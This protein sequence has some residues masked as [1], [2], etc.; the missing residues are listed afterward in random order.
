MPIKYAFLNLCF[1]HLSLDNSHRQFLNT[2]FYESRQVEHF[3][4]ILRHMDNSID[5]HFV[6]I[7]L[8][9]VML[10]WNIQMLHTSPVN[11]SAAL[12]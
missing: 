4:L 12:P 10:R 11:P 1:D 7:R 3:Y 8:R 2:F 6:K 9:A 5:A